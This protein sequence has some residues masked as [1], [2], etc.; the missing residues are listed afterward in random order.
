MIFSKMKYHF[1]VII[2]YAIYDLSIDDP[3]IYI[4][5]RMEVFQGGMIK[6]RGLV[7]T[8]FIVVHTYTWIHNSGV[9]IDLKQY[10]HLLL[11]RTLMMNR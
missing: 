4:Y 10:I 8:T 6:D 11:M 2:R 5:Q 7:K 3:Y 9:N 1:I